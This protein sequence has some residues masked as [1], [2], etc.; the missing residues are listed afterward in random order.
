MRRLLFILI[1]LLASVWFGLTIM[2]HPGYVFIVYQP[3]MMQMPLWFAFIA[4]FVAFSLFYL[5]INSIDRLK[6]F[7]YRMKNWLRFRREHRSYSKTQHGL[8]A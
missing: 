1:F 3:W 4:L 7:L 2:Q 5:L 8:A 6:F